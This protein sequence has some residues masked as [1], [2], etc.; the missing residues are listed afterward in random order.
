MAIPH[1]NEVPDH[2]KHPVGPYRQAPEEFG[3]DWWMVN[4]FTGS[5][6]WKNQKRPNERLPVGFV[7]IFGPRPRLADYL[8]TPS[9]SRSWKIATLQWEQ[10]L[11]YFKQAGLPEWVTDEEFAATTRTFQAWG[12][13]EPQFYEGRYG[14]MVRFPD[15]LVRAFETTAWG[16][17][18][19]THNVIAGYQLR[20]LDHGFVPE[21][22]HPFVPPQFWPKESLSEEEVA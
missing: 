4:P 16:A 10:D 1:Y 12:M 18:R 9:P 6:P 7:A 11:R 21:K 19:A 3:G 8:N 2:W 13:G 5:E 15:S 14:F 22:R 17:I 20:A